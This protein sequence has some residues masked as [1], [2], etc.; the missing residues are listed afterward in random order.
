MIVAY[1]RD[2]LK[3]EIDELGLGMEL[4]EVTNPGRMPGKPNDLPLKIQVRGPADISEF[5]LIYMLQMMN[6]VKQDIENDLKTFDD[7]SG[8]AN[9]EG[10]KLD[11]SIYDPSDLAF[12]DTS[13][14]TSSP[15]LSSAPTPFP[16][17]ESGV[18]KAGI[19]EE[20]V[21]NGIPWWVWLIVV[22]A[23]L[24][25]C[26]CCICYC[27]RLRRGNTEEDHKFN[28]APQVSQTNI[29]TNQLRSRL[30]KRRR[31]MDSNMNPRP[32]RRD[33]HRRSRGPSF[34]TQRSRR[35]VRTRR[36][37]KRP[38]RRSTAESATPSRRDSPQQM[39]VNT[40]S[41]RSDSPSLLRPEVGVPVVLRDDPPEENVLALYD[42]RAHSQNKAPH[43]SAQAEPEGDKVMR[44]QSVFADDHL[45]SEVRREQQ[46]N[47]R[48]KRSARREKS[49]GNR[50]KQSF[51][52]KQRSDATAEGDGNAGVRRYMQNDPVDDGIEDVA[53]YHSTSDRES[54][55][56]VASE[57]AGLLSNE[58]HRTKKKKPK[59]A[60]KEKKS[61]DKKASSS[62]SK[63]TRS[64][65]DRLKQSFNWKQT[66]FPIDI[67]AL[68]PS[69]SG[70]DS[71]SIL[72]NHNTPGDAEEGGAHKMAYDDGQNDGGYYRNQGRQATGSNPK[73]KKTRKS[74]NKKG[75]IFSSLRRKSLEIDRDG[76]V[77]DEESF[78]M[79][80]DQV[81]EAYNDEPRMKRVGSYSSA[82]CG[83]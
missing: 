49:M 7:G 78:H 24:L 52:R 41:S 76:V 57:P 74:G 81:N 72:T 10:V 53:Y 70:Y 82:S 1:M 46:A 48:R 38:S 50:L 4:I 67:E 40:K 59:S 8:V 75:G 45:M 25:C 19:M 51:K 64:M 16:Q 69:D 35:T 66:D 33:G 58:A 36:T 20:S 23:T 22:L 80:S 15:I 31:S 6:D 11:I 17:L 32:Q 13:A 2:V 62:R 68:S 9:F 27:M 42:P 30:S 61:S 26:I 18:Q 63:A 55:N 43:N 29:H 47:A 21:E 71:P 77:S 56:R 3:L 83:S 44:K 14:P 65:G 60:R 12:G 37:D 54:S 73:Q 39:V 79:E 5:A 28:D 34:T